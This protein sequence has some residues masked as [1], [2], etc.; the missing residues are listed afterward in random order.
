MIVLTN[1]RN[2]PRTDYRIG[3]PSRHL[4]GALNSDWDGYDADFEPPLHRVQT[5][6][7]AWDG[8]AQ[9]RP[10]LRPVRR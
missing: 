9:V 10:V 4:E 5:D 7:I 6:A 1:F 8:M 3:R 2:Q